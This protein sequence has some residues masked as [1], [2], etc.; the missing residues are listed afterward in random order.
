MAENYKNI[1]FVC[2]ANVCRSPF[3]EFYFRKRINELKKIDLHVSSRGISASPSFQIPGV[4]IRLL[5][6]E[7][8]KYITHIP[9]TITSRDTDEAD[10][11]LCMESHHCQMLRIGFPQQASKIQQLHEFATGRKKDIF[12]PIGQSDA[13]YELC[14]KEIRKCIDEI[15]K[16][17]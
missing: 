3:A 1:I 6:K 14:Y 11:I 7:G 16:K 15:L 8:I 13:Y 2:T 4:L 9:M 5:Q 12:D 17:I 10:L